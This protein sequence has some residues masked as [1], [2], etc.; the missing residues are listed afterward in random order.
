RHPLVRS[1]VYGAATAGE[2]RFAHRALAAALGSDDESADRRAWHLAASVVEHDEEVVR[3]LEEV[4]ERAASRAAFMVAV[5]AL[6][7]A[8]ELSSDDAGRGRDLV[9]AA[10]WASRAAQDDKA[11]SLAGRASRLVDTPHERAELAEVLGLAEIRCGRPAEVVPV[12]IEA[13]RAVTAIEPRRAL[14]LL[15]DGAWASSM[16]GDYRMLAEIVTLAATVSAPAGDEVACFIADSLTGF[17]AIAAGDPREGVPR[18]QRAVGWA[19]NADAPRWPLWAS[20]D[21]MLLGDHQRAAA[22]ASHG[23]ALA[24]RQGEVGVLAQGLGMTTVQS[25]FAQRFDE[26][27]LAGEEAVQYAREFQSDNQLALWHGAL[28]CVGAI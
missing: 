2:R 17:G 18:L 10:R 26:A 1:A 8:V 24:R 14:E 21:A 9:E 27:R 15:L 25:L 13:A 5:R 11:V 16:G 28:A 23:V 3:A 12:L 7:R 6:E 20:A 19:G 22:L 4:A